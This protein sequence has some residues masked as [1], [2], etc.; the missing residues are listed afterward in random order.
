[1]K[2]FRYERRQLITLEGRKAAAFHRRQARELA[3]YPLLAAEIAETQISIDEAE[4]RRNA[5]GERSEQY[6][7]DF[8]ARVWKESRRDYFASAAPIRQAIRTMWQG[9][10]GP[11]TCIYFRY[12]VDR[13]TGEFERRSQ[14]AKER[15]M[16]LRRKAR[17]SI[18]HQPA[19]NLESMENLTRG[20]TA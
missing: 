19:L 4:A 13:C 1:M 3:R 18:G 16:A 15:D 6:Q 9:W 20:A 2:F 11:K 12:V 5:I 8:N 10:A 14:V 17:A 7:R